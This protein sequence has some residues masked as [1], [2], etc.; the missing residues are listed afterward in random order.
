[1][2][3]GSREH[4]KVEQL[5]GEWA[6]RHDVTL[7]IMRPALIFGKGVGAWTQE[8][9]DQVARG[10]YVHIRGNDART[11]VVMASD[12]ARAMVLLAGKTGIYNVSDGRPHTWLS[13]AEAMAA[14]AGTNKRVILLS[15]K[16]ADRIFR[17]FWRIRVVGD[18]LADFVLAEKASTL[19]L[20]D[21][22][23]REATG[24]EFYDA[25]EVIARRDKDY[26]YE[27]S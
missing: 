1:M 12:A 22:R 4:V 9:F 3:M 10:H 20:D 17:Y 11:S 5:F 23:V 21:S 19:V 8:F 18:A 16:W 2:S 15:A 7:A 14:N 25:I 24:M 26:P 6:A 27:D 13:L